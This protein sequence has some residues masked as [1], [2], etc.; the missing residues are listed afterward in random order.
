MKAKL[1]KHNTVKAKLVKESLI[2]E[3]SDEGWL[4]LESIHEL[5]TSKYFKEWDVDGGFDHN[6]SLYYFINDNEISI[7]LRFFKT[8]MTGAI[9][10]DYYVDDEE[11]EDR[12]TLFGGM[13]E[14]ASLTDVDNFLEGFMDLIYKNI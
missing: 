7:K 12:P 2:N 5:M 11:D 10:L 8:G 4:S 14:F 6:K 1:K 3:S 13:Q 9:T